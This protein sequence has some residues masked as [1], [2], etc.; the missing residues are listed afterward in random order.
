MCSEVDSRSEYLFPTCSL[1]TSLVPSFSY[2]VLQCTVCTPQL[3]TA[4]LI[5]LL[6]LVARELFRIPLVA[7]RRNELSTS[8]AISFSPFP[9]KDIDAMMYNEGMM[10]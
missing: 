9:L 7:T 3:I 1:A 8:S 10:K 6:L 5:Q 2:A 4:C